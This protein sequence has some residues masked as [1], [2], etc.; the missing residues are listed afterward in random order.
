VLRLDVERNALIVGA[1][2]EL[3]LKAFR[4]GPISWVAGAPPA[5]DVEVEVQIRYRSR[6]VPAA[7]DVLPDGG[8]TVLMETPL[9]DV[10]PGQAAVFYHHDRCLGNGLI[11]R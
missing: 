5:N 4:T 9:R 11:L 7:I 2:E 1:A 6:A 10:T 8:A 3:G